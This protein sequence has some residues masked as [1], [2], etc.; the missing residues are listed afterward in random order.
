MLSTFLT[1]PIIASLCDRCMLFELATSGK[2][3]KLFQNV[4]T[5]TIKLFNKQVCFIFQRK[6][7]H[8]QI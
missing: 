2:I 1:E 6:R 7:T 5:D 8:E 4:T 3:E